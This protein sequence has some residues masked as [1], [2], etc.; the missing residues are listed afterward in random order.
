MVGKEASYEF[1]WR[2]WAL[3]RD[4][5][6]THLEGKSSGSRFPGFNSIGTALGVSSIE[7]SAPH[8][9]RELATIREEL[10]TRTLADLVI[11]VPTA[12]VLYPTIR[13]TGPRSLTRHELHQLAPAGD[14]ETLD[15]Y[16]SSMLES[17]LDVCASPNQEGMIEVLDG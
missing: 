15:Q 2:R 7:I 13:A 9:A 10:A 12:S 17:M 6:V 5:V 8:L 11:D 16:F 3:L 4:V 14:S 1:R